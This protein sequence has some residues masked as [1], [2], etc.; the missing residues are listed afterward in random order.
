M[1]RAATILALILFVAAGCAEKHP[2]AEKRIVFLLPGV[3]GGKYETLARAIEE[4]AKCEVRIMSWGA[5]APLFMLNFSNQKIHDDAERKLADAILEYR[6]THP[7]AEVDLIGHSAGCGVILGALK[8]LPADAHVHTVALLAPSVS[9]KYDLTPAILKLERLHVFTSSLDTVF[10]KWRTSRFGTYDNIKTPAAG[11]A[12]FDLT[13]LS[14]ELRAKVVAHPYDDAWKSLG[15]DGGHFGTLSADF[16]NQIIAP[17]FASPSP[18]D[19]SP[20]Q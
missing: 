12:G 4:S 15:N 16:T 6:R 8:R 17:L 9:P 5:P 10:L 18:P 1:R 14:S 3:A 13:P 7:A 2:P 11:N 19:A 20:S